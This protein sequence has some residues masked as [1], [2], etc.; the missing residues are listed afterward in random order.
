M[1][2]WDYMRSTRAC[3]GW[4]SRGGQT[5]NPCV[6]DR[7]PLGS[8]SGS[9]VAVAANLCT[10]AQDKR[11]ADRIKAVVVLVTCW[12]TEGIAEVLQVDPNTVRNHFKCYRQGGIEALHRIGTGVGGSAC[13]LDAEQLASLGYYETFD[14]F[15]AACEEPFSNPRKYHCELRS[16]LTARFFIFG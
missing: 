3:S 15:R 10:A 8:S 5:R 1:S 6:L 4:S 9:A 12:T 2:E 14:E 13:L 11:E 16:L 7:S